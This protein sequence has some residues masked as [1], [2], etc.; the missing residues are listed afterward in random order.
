MDY[1]TPPASPGEQQALWETEAHPL[2]SHANVDL[3]VYERVIVA[4]SGGKDS[5][6]C[7]LDLLERGVPASRI[8]LHH[9]LVDGQDEDF[10]DWPCTE[11]YCRAFAT[12]FGMKITFSFKEG[13]FEREMLRDNQPTA[14]T[15]IPCG[16]GYKLI[17]GKGRCDTRRKFPQVTSNLSQRWCSSY[18]KIS[19]MDA[20]IKNDP[21]FLFGKTLV[22]TGERAQ[23]S[24]S[25]AK[26]KQFEPHRADNRSGT[27]VKRYVDHLRPVHQWSEEQV[28][29]IMERFL[30][31]AHPCYFLGW[32]R[33]SCLSCIFGNKDQW[34]SVKLIV[35]QRFSKIAKYE[36]EFGVTIHRSL[37]IEQL[38]SAGS[39]HDMDPF[40]VEVAIGKEYTLPIIMDQ[41]ELPSG[42]YG[43]LGCGP[44]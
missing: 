34:A 35:P 36:R 17:G 27:R 19:C 2:V 39:P 29:A 10:M 16:D 41:W 40:W 3:S 33:A 38:A 12:A 23:E 11:A 22:V 15:A 1:D 8:H 37:S 20:W 30:V 18:M 31:R 28:W 4:F 42:A 24:K 32:G 44:S 21:Q 5:V 9:H 6:A 25:R 13:G 26:Y 7:V 14:P 43:D